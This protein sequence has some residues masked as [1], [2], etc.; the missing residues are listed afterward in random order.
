[1]LLL[2]RLKID[3]FIA[4]IYNGPVVWNKELNV[5]IILEKAFEG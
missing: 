3:Y 4:L 1:M 5:Y 2:N